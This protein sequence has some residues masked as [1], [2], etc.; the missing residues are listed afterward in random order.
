VKVASETGEEKKH[1]LLQPPAGFH[2]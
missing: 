1:V 2:D